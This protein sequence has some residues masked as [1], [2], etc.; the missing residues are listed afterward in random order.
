MFYYYYYYY[1]CSFLLFLFLLLLFP[2]CI[3]D[4]LMIDM[5]GSITF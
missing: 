2:Q 3:G 4:Y 5:D 1:Y